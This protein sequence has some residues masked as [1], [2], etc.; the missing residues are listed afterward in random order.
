MKKF[1]VLFILLSSISSA[2]AEEGV[3]YIQKHDIRGGRPINIHIVYFEPCSNCKLELTYG[4]KEI[5]ER[6]RVENFAKETNAYVAMN[7]SY[8][9]QDTGTPLGLSIMNGKL[10]TGPLFDRSVFGIDKHGNCL[11]GRASIEGKI[12]LDRNCIDIANINQPATSIAAGAYLYNYHWGCKTPDTSDDYL[13]IVVCKNRIAQ[14]SNI[15]VNIPTGGYAIVVAK[16]FI[17]DRLRKR[18][19]AKY[20][21]KLLPNEFCKLQYAFAGGPNLIV[22]GE[23]NVDSIAQ[24]FNIFFVKAIT[25]RSAIGI[26]QDGTVILLAVDGKQKGVSEGVNLYELSDIMCELGAYQAMNLDGGSSTQMAINKQMVNIPTNRCGARVTNAV[27]VVKKK[28][29]FIF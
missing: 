27:V 9:K 29:N 24:K 13:H 7:A 4:N 22:N 28:H 20:C 21:Y 12:S 18:A 1:L 5:T 6:M 23:K 14:I 15:S 17:T 16:S 8:F 10:M 2:F 11:I 26:K 25:A 3:T 19:P